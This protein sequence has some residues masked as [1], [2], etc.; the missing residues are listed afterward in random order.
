MFGNLFGLGTA[1][2]RVQNSSKAQKIMEICQRH[3][4]KIIVG[5]EPDQP[6]NLNAFTKLQSKLGINK[7]IGRNDLCYCGSGK[8]FKRCCDFS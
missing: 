8:K 4:W 2:V 3:N 6:E 7:N 1:V 5:I